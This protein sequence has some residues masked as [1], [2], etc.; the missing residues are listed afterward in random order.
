[1]ERNNSLS[2]VEWHANISYLGQNI[3]YTLYG[4]TRFQNNLFL[5]IEV[6][7]LTTDSNRLH[8]SAQYAPTNRSWA[9]VNTVAVVAL[10]IQLLRVYK[11]GYNPC[12]CCC[13]CGGW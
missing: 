11:C 13:F 1:M 7:H 6:I 3:I 5:G 4:K 10:S 9:N 12:C 8:S 2:I